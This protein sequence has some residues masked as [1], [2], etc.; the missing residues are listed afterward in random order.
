MKLCSQH[1][2][3]EG[4]CDGRHLQCICTSSLQ[5]FSLP[6]ILMLHRLHWLNPNGSWDPHGGH[7]PLACN[8]NILGRVTMIWLWQQLLASGDIRAGFLNKSLCYLHQTNRRESTGSDR[9]RE[10]QCSI[11]I[12]KQGILVSAA[13]WGCLKPSSNSLDSTHTPTASR[14]GPPTLMDIKT[15]NLQEKDLRTDKYSEQPVWLFI[16]THI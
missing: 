13:K 10:L 14:H 6:M 2:V 16:W 12:R 3:P 11:A 15:Y 1:Q 8:M 9:L 5:P 7:W 4:S